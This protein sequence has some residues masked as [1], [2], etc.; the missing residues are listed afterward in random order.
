MTENYLEI[1]NAALRDQS[2]FYTTAEQ[3]RERQNLMIKASFEYH[4][5]NCQDY[6]KFCEG[7]AVSPKD[8]NTI[9]DLLKIPL[10]DSFKTLRKRQFLSVPK[11]KI[12]SQ[13]CSTGSSGKPLLWI[14]L[15]QITMD[16][17]IQASVLFNKTMIEFKPGATLLMLPYIPQLKFAVVSKAILANLNQTSYFGL[18]AIFKKDPLPK[19]EPDMKAIE[20]FIKDPAPVKNL[21][22][23]PFTITQ[24][25]EYLKSKDLELSLGKDGMIV[26]GGG[27]KPR[28][29]SSEY[30]NMSREEIERIISSAFH[31]PVENIRDAYGCTEILLGYIECKRHR[32]HVP[33]WCYHVAVDSDDLTLLN[34][35]EKGLGAC[36]DFAVH[37]YPGFI[38]T[39]DYIRI[40]KE[41]CP[42]GITGQTIEYIGRIQ[43][44][45]P[46]GCSFK[47]EDK[48]FSEAYLEGSSTSPTTQSMVGLLQYMLQN[49]EAITGEFLKG[50]ADF[51][52]KAMDTIIETITVKKVELPLA[53]EIE[54]LQFVALGKLMCYKQG[55][56]TLLPEQTIIDQMSDIKPEVTRGIL[57]LFEERRFIKKVKKDGQW[58]YK[59]TKKADEFGEAFYPLLIWA[60][61]YTK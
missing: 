26:T 1:I 51:L 13:F 5:S 57:Q 10:L 54:T 19:I 40:Y 16:W 56:P 17:M 2:L 32:Y 23:F 11:N 47:F 46:R 24:L 61:K 33:P 53:E 41:P 12:V 48:L 9:E 36:Y 3:L 35:G 43:D 25:K 60:I 8:I 49:K 45:D 38:L 58:F 37:S 34:E 59:F 7:R 20:A 4:Y 52:R 44:E 27:W 30:A 42:C 28:Q 21:I 31:V 39:E 6:R 14:S 55:K 50:N 15:D 29:K 22:G 18:K